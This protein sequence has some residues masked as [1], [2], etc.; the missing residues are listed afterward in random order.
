MP[1]WLVDTSLWIDLFSDKS[2]AVATFLD[3]YLDA[4]QIY[5]CDAI[6]LELVR[7]VRTEKEKQRLEGDLNAFRWAET[8]EMV[9]QRARQLAFNLRRKGVSTS[10]VDT[11]I[12]ATALAN[13]LG[14]L[15]CD[16]DFELISNHTEL[17]QT[18][19]NQ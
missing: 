14:L 15:H 18:S 9:W 10:T 19:P 7:G 16:R 11:L 12:A 8:T 13:D 6:H 2:G 5:V 4:D 17:K 1:G 3:P